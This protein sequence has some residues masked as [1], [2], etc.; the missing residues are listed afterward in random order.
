MVCRFWYTNSLLSIL[1]RGVFLDQMP[2]KSKSWKDGNVT[3]QNNIY[4]PEGYIFLT[5]VDSLF[6]LSPSPNS[7]IINLGF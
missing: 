2:F 4:I 1:N 6:P 3:G 5:S 7:R